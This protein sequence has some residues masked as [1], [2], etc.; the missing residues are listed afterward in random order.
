MEHEYALNLFSLEEGKFNALKVDEVYDELAKQIR[1]N[2]LS[3]EMSVLDEARSMNMLFLF[4]EHMKTSGITRFVIPLAA[5]EWCPTCH[6]RGFFY[7]LE[8]YSLECPVCKRSGHLTS[9]C[10]TCLGQGTYI[11][12][13][14]DGRNRGKVITKVC[15][16]CSSGLIIDESRKC[17]KC[18]G[19]GLIQRNSTEL[20]SH[21]LCRSC[22]G[23]GRPPAPS[24]TVISEEDAKRIKDSIVLD[25]EEKGVSAS[26]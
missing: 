4:Q 26:A 19:S 10:P 1:L 23:S 17:R 6:G 22:H 5:K 15:D 3:L 7:R 21:S 20:I 8:T 9:E 13:I 14:Y 11:V 16:H 18:K 12:P 25:V 2:N 24:N